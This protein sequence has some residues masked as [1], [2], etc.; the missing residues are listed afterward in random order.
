M[1][2]INYAKTLEPGP[3]PVLITLPWQV[4]GGHSHWTGYQNSDASE[5]PATDSPNE[6]TALF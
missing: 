6:T 3:G 4:Q 2:S 5:C 1:K